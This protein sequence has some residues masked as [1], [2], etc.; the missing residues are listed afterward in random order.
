ME[1]NDIQALIDSHC[2]LDFEVF[3]KDRT[4]MLLRAKQHG[5]EAMIIPG[6]S[7]RQWRTV[8]TLCN[9]HKQLHPCY[10]LHPYFFNQHKEADLILLDDWLG[11]H[12][13]V[14]LGECGLDYRKDQADKKIQ[15]KFFEAQLDIAVTHQ[16]P[17]VIHSVHANEDVIHSL[18]QRPEL[19]GMIHSYSGSY[20]QAMQFIELGFYISLSG[21]L[22]YER[23]NKLRNVAAKISLEKLLLETDSPDQP[24]TNH[25]GKRNEP[26]YLINILDCLSQL[27]TE[28]KEAI[29]LK[30]TANARKLFNI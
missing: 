30:T 21:Q 13:C 24:D 4:E 25:Q 14:A 12:G 11:K 1:P 6:I 10:G 8:K 3:D 27:R 20:E 2:H 29:A 15:K 28:N 23:A 19:N 22:T 18:R 5:I 17:V 16:L 7:S 26:A 9:T